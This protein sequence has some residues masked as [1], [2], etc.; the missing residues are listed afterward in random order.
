MSSVGYY[1][2]LL[3]LCNIHVYI[4][5]TTSSIETNEVLEK[6]Q[7][8]AAFQGKFWDFWVQLYIA[9]QFYIQME[10]FEKLSFRIP[11]V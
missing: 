3:L 2:I 5:C 10:T 1:G 8:E 9:C 4:F 7:F 6:A 11:G